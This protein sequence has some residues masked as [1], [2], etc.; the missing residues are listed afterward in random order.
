MPPR[1]RP[2][3]N[4]WR[5]R[6]GIE[7]RA[8]PE[9]SGVPKPIE[10]LRASDQRAAKAGQGTGE[11]APLHLMAVGAERKHIRRALSRCEGSVSKTAEWLGISRETLWEKMKR[12]EVRV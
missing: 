2:V 6:C 1:R 11:F 12:L 9:L 8:T 10:P 4:A 5:R 7:S 3:P